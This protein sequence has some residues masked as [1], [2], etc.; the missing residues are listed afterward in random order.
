ME[1]QNI[2]VHHAQVYGNTKS[3]CITPNPNC[4]EKQVGKGAVRQSN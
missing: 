1:T 4:I 3:H 2:I